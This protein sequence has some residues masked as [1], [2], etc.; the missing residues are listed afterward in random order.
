MADEATLRIVVEGQGGGPGAGAPDPGKSPLSPPRGAATIPPKPSG[1]SA[2]GANDNFFDQVIAALRQMTSIIGGGLGRLA[3]AL[4]DMVVS[5]RRS[6]PKPEVITPK[7][8]APKP[9]TPSAARPEEFE[10]PAPEEPPAQPGGKGTQPAP[11][12]K[13]TMP[14]RG[15]GTMPAPAGKG[16][17]P[18]T[19]GKG[20]MP[21][22]GAATLP[23]EGEAAGAGAAAA[24]AALT[25][26]AAAAIAAAAAITMLKNAAD[27]AVERYA[28]YSPVLAGVYVQA[29]LATV[30]ADFRR[31]Q[32]VG[33]ALAQYLQARTELQIKYEDAKMRLLT[34]ATP[35]LVRLM[36]IAEML[37]P[38]GEESL[39][40]LVDIF[41]DV[42]KVLAWVTGS[43]GDKK[44]AMPDKLGALT[45]ALGGDW[46]PVA[47]EKAFGGK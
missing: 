19:T 13:G 2:A 21:A 12:G 28:P 25:I 22:P 9:V 1:K 5:I 43:K 7:R 38:V 36:E 8:P 18:A 47:W 14:A 33:P 6:L 46:S 32:Q 34:R 29:Q 42:A 10:M 16:T 17:M 15:R 35:A 45:E 24:G 26:V 20:T 40:V 31:G 4:L 30:M 41:G 23:A 39:G 11:R 44:D 27:E 3:S 37:L